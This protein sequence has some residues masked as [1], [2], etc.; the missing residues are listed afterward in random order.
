[1]PTPPSSAST[2]ESKRSASCQPPSSVPLSIQAQKRRQPSAVRVHVEPVRVVASV[3]VCWRQ[4]RPQQSIHRPHLYRSCPPA[5][6]A[7]RNTLV[8]LTAL[9]DRRPIEPPST[10]AMIIS[11]SSA[12]VHRPRILV[13]LRARHPS[14]AQKELLELL[15]TV[16]TL[17]PIHVRPVLPILRVLL[18][19]LGLL[20]LRF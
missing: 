15:D 9:Q 8:V 2:H 7:N 12:N 11:D 1:M 3:F 18:A 19:L 10:S 20:L 5:M 6:S 4:Q 16:T 17:A 13:H 14:F